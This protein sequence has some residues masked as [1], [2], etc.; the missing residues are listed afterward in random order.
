MTT[1]KSPDQPESFLPLGIGN[2]ARRALAGAGY[3]RLDQLTAVTEAALKRMH[4]VGPKAID[5]L[6]RALSANG[7]SFADGAR[8]PAMI[9]G[10]PV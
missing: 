6:R 8:E 5:V 10:A 3:V 1:S 7:M 2:P 4:G 9:E